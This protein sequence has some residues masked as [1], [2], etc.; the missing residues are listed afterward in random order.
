MTY[1]ASTMKVELSRIEV[2]DLLIAC[3]AAEHETGAKKWRSLHEKLKAQLEAFDE[4]NG[5]GVFEQ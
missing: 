1:N 4:S 5:Y 3:L 2:C